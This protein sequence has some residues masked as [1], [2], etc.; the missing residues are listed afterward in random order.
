MTI[1]V[2][3]NANGGGGLQNDNIIAYDM[4]GAA[5]APFDNDSGGQ[6][7]NQATKPTTFTTCTLCLT[8]TVGSGI[9]FY[10]ANWNFGTATAETAPTGG[11]F[12]S[13]WTNM[14]NVNG[15]QPLDQNGGWGHLYNGNTS[16]I[17][18]T[19][20]LATD[21]VNNMGGWAGRAAHFLAAVNKS[22][23]ITL[24]GIGPC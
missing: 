18:V 23:T 5:A 1:A 13:A 19:W 22:C 7:G 24:T 20:T 12:D 6:S 3:R 11:V 15:P 16:A 9:V 21:G 10:N 4:V 8:P 14:N 2:T 17:T